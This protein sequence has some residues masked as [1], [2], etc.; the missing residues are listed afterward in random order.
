M[1]NNQSPIFGG[2]NAYSGDTL[3]MLVSSSLPTDSKAE[4][5]N[6]G[7]WVG[8]VDVLELARLANSHRPIL[9]THNAKGDRVDQVAFHPSWQA[10]MRKSKAAGLGGS[11]WEQGA[12]DK[13]QRHL[14]RAAKL[15]MTAEVE[16]GHLGPMITSNASIATLIKSPNI[17]KE[18]LPLIVSR[19]YDSS[20]NAP[21]KKTSVTIGLAT[22][23]RQA[24][25][26][27]QNINSTATPDGAKN[28]GI[29]KI[30]GAKWFVSAPMCDAFLVLAKTPKGPTC[31]LMPRILP[32]GNNNG[33]QLQRLKEKM[34]NRSN[35]TCEI[36]LVN[37]LGQMVGIEGQGIA[38]IAEMR[39][40]ILVDSSVTSAGLMRA[41]VWEAVE[42]CRHRTVSGT[43][44]IDQPLMQRVLAD[45]AIDV[46]A[47]TVLSFRL[48][49]SYDRGG[50]NPTEQ[51][52]SRLMT[53]VIKYWT[54]KIAPSILAECLE[55]IGI[56][57]YAEESNVA[58]QYREAPLNGLWEGG[59]NKHC[60]DVI[61]L[62]SQRP[63]ILDA[64]LSTLE[65]DL[66]G[67]AASKTVNVIRTAH[68]MAVDD[69]GSARILTE[70]LALTA[71]AAELKRIGLTELADAFI[72]T[73]LGGLWRSTYG[74][75]DT[76]QKA[77]S[78]INAL[79]P[80]N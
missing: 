7:K 44:L 41:G 37:A 58:R 20:Y 22:T 48:A 79:Y 14:S 53:P 23:E 60:L 61:D 8:S 74:M 54:T 27:L 26:D 62:I 29:W 16:M 38:A 63:E 42:H 68:A 75:L 17:V 10:F 71:A 64:V 77:Q 57:G 55:C 69:K 35:A 5:E 73:R 2:H 11:I 72:E 18:W 24:G 46:A 78:I 1:G 6:L 9:K 30:N 3:L 33:F 31:F 50:A 13:G 15:F 65:R 28:S 76:R 21:A 70:Q 36:N 25:V 45:M 56:N 59:G 39:N 51:A 4:L 47:S 12:K 32:N 49:Q 67:Q 80:Q 19:K 66:G 43:K 52:Y 34:G 40:L